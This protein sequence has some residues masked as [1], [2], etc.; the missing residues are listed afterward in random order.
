MIKVLL[1][2]DEKLALEYLEHIISW[3]YY[4]FELIG[5]STD[6]EQ[7]LNLYKK[8]KPELVISDVKMPG[9]NGLEFVHA[10]REY[11]GKSHILFLSSYKSFD[12]VKQAIRLDI[13]DYLLK[14]D[15]EEESFLKKI[16]KLKEAINKEQAK[17]Q[18]TLG[19]ILE[20][21]FKKNAL[22]ENYKFMLEENDYIRIHKKYYYILL[23][24][25]ISPRF[26]EQYLSQN[27]I[28]PVSFEFEFSKTCYAHCA[29]DGIQVMAVFA[30][31]ENEYLAVLEIKDNMVAQKEINDKIY[32]YSR[33]I[34]RDMNEEQA[35]QFDLYYYSKK[36]STRQFG[37][38]YH[39]NRNQLSQVYLKKEVHIMEF[40]E[41]I[42]WKSA[43]KET[44]SITSDEIYQKIK[45]EDKEGILQCIQSVKI[46]MAEENYVSYLWYIKNLFEAISFF[47]GSLYGEK[48]GRKFSLSENSNSYDFRSPKEL[49]AFIEF[50]LEEIWFFI[51]ESGKKS[52]SVVVL[53]AVRY[54]KRQYYDPQLSSAQVANHV[55]ISASWLSTKF[56]EEV[57][58]GVSDFMNGIR[59]EQAKEMFDRGDYMIYEVSEKVGFTSSQYFSKIFKEFV[60]VTPNQYRRKNDRIK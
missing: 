57:G 26:L 52:Y 27:N 45:K 36:M 28:P 24:Q 44:K 38:F 55:N 56:K 33:K 42:L 30:I 1:V 10:I 16:L 37:R 20:E 8:Y 21:L 22:E 13:D 53:E 19:I 12:Y 5:V 14:S 25:K 54:I 11:G 9:M 15:L 31:N 7:A 40:V 46:A 32:Y 50:K 41:D 29:E 34:F 47:E 6:A 2:D 18:Y 23:S 17:N 3:E 60:G 51:S 39:E 43:G 49:V 59:V 58:I 35:H 4:D 48:S